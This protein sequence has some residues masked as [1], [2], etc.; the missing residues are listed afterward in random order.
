MSLLRWM[1]VRAPDGFWRLAERDSF[2]L[3]T[4]VLLTGGLGA[5]IGALVGV[6]IRS[7]A[8]DAAFVG[9]MIGLGGGFVW[10]VFATTVHGVRWLRRR[11]R[12]G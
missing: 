1:F 9:C 6:L 11:L 8:S 10:I 7:S 3:P 12:K 4:G 5:G 2:W